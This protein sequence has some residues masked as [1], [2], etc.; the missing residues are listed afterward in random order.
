[1]VGI[2][3]RG[4]TI[5]G[6]SAVVLGAYVAVHQDSRARG[7]TGERAQDVRKAGAY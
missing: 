2:V 7:E 6:V 5:Y 4:R 3:V 1:M